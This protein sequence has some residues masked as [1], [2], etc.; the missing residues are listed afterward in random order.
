MD[1]I[2]AA[3]SEEFVSAKKPRQVESWFLDIICKSIPET[4][5]RVHLSKKLTFSLK[6]SKFSAKNGFFGILSWQKQGISDI[7]MFMG[8]FLNSLSYTFR[9]SR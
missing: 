4:Q 2:E 8:F 9:N 6:K 3:T 7:Y 1:K 5:W